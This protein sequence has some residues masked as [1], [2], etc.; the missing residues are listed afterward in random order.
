MTAHQ[1]RERGGIAAAG[2]VDESSVWRAVHT[3]HHP[4]PKIDSRHNP[5]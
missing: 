2:F 1:L 3:S 4:I 5:I